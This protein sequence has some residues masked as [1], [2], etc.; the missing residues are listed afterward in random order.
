MTTFMALMA[1]S[2]NSLP[3]VLIVRYCFDLFSFLLDYISMNYRIHFIHRKEENKV[4]ICDNDSTK[5]RL[6]IQLVPTP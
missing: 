6:K 2:N 3:H 1:V 5:M 4:L